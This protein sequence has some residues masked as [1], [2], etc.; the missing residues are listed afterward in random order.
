[1][2]KSKIP[3]NLQVDG[4]PKL[5]ARAT[6][7]DKH[8]KSE[9]NIEEA[10]VASPR[11]T[12]HRAGGY[13]D[14]EG[15]DAGEEEPSGKSAT[16]K[17]KRKRKSTGADKAT[18]PNKQSDNHDIEDE[19][20]VEGEPSS[21]L[22]A[23]KA[24]KKSK[25]TAANKA[26][27]STRQSDSLDI[28]GEDTAEEEPSS[29]ALAPKTREKTKVTTTNKAAKPRKKG[30]DL[31]V[32]GTSKLAAKSKST[33]KHEQADLN[34]EEATVA[35]IEVEKLGKDEAKP[36]PK[37][38]KGKTAKDGAGK[39][40]REE[41]TEQSNP[42]D[43]D[44]PR[45][46]R[47]ESSRKSRK[48]TKKASAVGDGVQMSSASQPEGKSNKS[49]AA[50]KKD[51][52]PEEIAAIESDVAM[53]E[54]PF[55]DLLESG[56]GK[57]S[58]VGK[59]E[60]EETSTKRRKATKKTSREAHLSNAKPSKA[61]TI[62]TSARAAGSRSN[63]INVDAEDGKMTATVEASSNETIAEVTVTMKTQPKGGADKAKNAVRA[64]APST[65]PVGEVARTAKKQTKAGVEKSK[66]LANADAPL[67]EDAADVAD[68]VTNK[69]KAG[70]DKG[71]QAV[72]DNAPS[73]ET[74]ARVADTVK[75]QTKAGAE[76]VKKG[77]KALAPSAEIPAEA[78][79]V[80]SKEAKAAAEKAKK[81][82]KPKEDNKS[83]KKVGL[84]DDKPQ[85]EALKSKKR[86]A[87]AVDTEEI[88]AHILD[89][90]VEH[91]EASA[92][93]K[94][95]QDKV[96]SK[97]IGDAVGSLISSAAEG[98]SAA[99]ASLGG[100]ASTLIGG[101]TD[102]MDGVVGTAEDATESAKSAAAK[103]TGK[104]KAM[105]EDVAESV[106]MAVEGVV[107]TAVNATEAT[108]STAKKAKGKGKAVVDNVAESVGMAV[109]GVVETA[110]D[111]TE[112]TK[113][114]ARKAT[115][116]GKAVAEDVAGTVG[117]AIDGV[118]ETA[119]N[120]TEAT[121]SAA[122]KAKGKGKAVA[123][124]VAESVGMAI[125]GVVETAADTTEATKSAAK[126]VKVK[127]KAVIQDAAESVSK[128]MAPEA[129]ADLEED[130]SNGD[131]SD[132]DFEHDDHTAALL[133]G[134]ESDGDE[135]PVTGLGFE[136]GQSLPEM[137]NE[138]ATK[139]K[140]HVIKAGT[141]EGPGVVYVGRIPHGFY[142]HEMREYFSQFGD[143][144]RLRLSRNKKTGASRHWAF[145]E[146]KSAG[147]AKI[148]ADT[149]NNYLMFGHILKCRVVPQEQLHENVWIG[150]DK[151]FKKVPW[152]KLEGRKHEVPVGRVQWEARNDNEEKRRK[153]KQEKMKEI[154]YEFEA[155][156]LKRVDQVPVKD[157]AKAIGVVE[158][159]DE[160]KSLVTAGGD[161]TTE[162]TVVSEELKTKKSKKAA[163]GEATETTITVMKKTKRVLET[164]EEASG[165]VTKK[166]K[167]VK[168]AVALISED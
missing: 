114:V 123:E 110:A 104:G 139:M 103:A 54:G 37:G 117:V 68:T 48:D 165:S 86:K 6:P 51:A 33:D 44:A 127:G 129:S 38:K 145:V 50:S 116:K 99:R 63:E 153:S 41:E 149:M 24:K 22:A 21:K 80:V 58:E 164:G 131:E 20:I 10:T 87:P 115:G 36:A 49:K 112:A 11:I 43:K 27:K 119:A 138:K 168:G 121:V 111:T 83:T 62:K 3:K 75:K 78:A 152:N 15:E 53:D 122:K 135:A 66:Q 60:E 25:S 144:N 155:P 85:L 162:P 12:R 98:A 79:N 2:A 161:D 108:K 28:Q 64:D 102:A 16:S 147:V 133:A 105:A 18:K 167:K 70:L 130:E 120:A 94:L 150:A 81:V 100:F 151:R 13:F 126:K 93:K 89:P 34:I 148:V 1:M 7:G 166:A 8:E 91:A 90:L 40:V 84:A 61:V 140:L 158:T 57:G 29:K 141:D 143:I 124:D 132:E 136:K 19:D 134:F 39:V 101:A 109:E 82:V 52:A 92:K 128:A 31:V 32:D 137:P 154:G 23:P 47:G 5:A 14:F 163:K 67:I 55:E 95:K 88:K 30:D 65:M 4:T 9:L 106:G 142:E 72:K 97:S 157:T 73:T 160:E 59:A 107:E 35:A 17:S 113:S 125:D 45:V 26:D 118:V 56:K 42:A 71:K 69:T 159:F 46:E 156:P 74:A 76:K 146:F 96:K 77:T